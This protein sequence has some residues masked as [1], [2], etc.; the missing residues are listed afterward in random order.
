MNKQAG[1]TLVELLVVIAIVAIL[2]G[3]TI[4]VINPVQ[5]KAK[6]NEVLMRSNLSKLCTAMVGCMALNGNASLCDTANKMG[7][8]V[9][10]GNPVGSSYTLSVATD[11]IYWS[12]YQTGNGS[13]NCRYVCIYYFTGAFL[14]PYKYPDSGVCLAN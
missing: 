7:V 1:F 8:S 6:A 14:N 3:A 4:M 12:G 9:P 11:R 2:A 10:T 13:V 5:Q